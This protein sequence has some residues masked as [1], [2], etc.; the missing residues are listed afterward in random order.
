MLGMNQAFACQCRRPAASVR[1][2]ESA[3]IA[4][5]GQVVAI[6]Y[7]D[8][9][10]NRCDIEAKLTRISC[11]TQKTRL[12]VLKPL[13]GQPED[14]VTLYTGTDSGACGYQFE[15]DAYLTVVAGRNSRGNLST[16]LCAMLAVN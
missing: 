14:V 7:L 4:F 10:G 8:E 11:S 9:W 1:I 12:R 2:V 13:K 6:E 15:K 5:V 3:D 16:N